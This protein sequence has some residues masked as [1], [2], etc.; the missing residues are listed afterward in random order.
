MKHIEVIGFDMDYTLVRYHAENFESMTYQEILRK[1]CENYHYPKAVLKLKFDYQR[2]IRGLV[3]DKNLGNVIK[4][5]LYSK[6]KKAFHGTEEIDFKTQQNIYQGLTID[7]NDNARYSIIDTTFSISH[8]VLFMQLVTLKDQHPELELPDYFQLNEHI[9]DCLDLSHRDGSLKAE[10][11]KNIKKYI[12][13][14][15]DS[16]RALEKLKKHGKKLWVI[17]NS[18]FNYSKLLLDYAINPFLKDYKH[19]K[20]LFSLVIT[21]SSKPKFFTERS[22]L[23]SVDLETGLMKNHQGKIKD[24]IYQGGNATSLQKDLGLSGEQILYLGDHIFGDVL[25]IKKTC[26]WRTGLVI[27][28]LVNEVECCKKSAT[29]LKL[30]DQLMAQKAKY[31]LMIDEHYDQSIEKGRSSQELKFKKKLQ[32]LYQK[33]H[34]I[35][36][37]LKKVIPR[38][39]Q[40]FN[41]YWGETMRAGQEPSR[42]AGQIEKYACIYMARVANFGDY[43]PRTYYRPMRRTLPHDILV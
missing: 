25:K 19:W 17:T 14:D 4:L 30:M 9:V 27:E 1:L 20:D 31:E 40:F 8:A 12:L 23:L 24:G 32:G 26:N 21:F 34:E 11:R 29:T 33:M 3:I 10:V 7:L 2:A 18:D 41:P 39:N 36:A 37:K 43:S 16:V 35:D 6:V 13:Q 22:P 38:Y 28:E 15:R 42:L 5:S